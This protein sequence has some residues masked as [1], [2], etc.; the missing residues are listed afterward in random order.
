MSVYFV[1][2]KGWRYDFTLNG[3]RYTATWFK[4]KREAV[5]AESAKRADLIKPQVEEILTDMPFL[6][7]VN[8][9]LDHV[10]AY[11]SERHYADY[12]Y[13]AR[14]W[15]ER[16]GELPCSHI[17]QE[18]IEEFLMDRASVSAFTAN[19][20]LRYLRAT[21]NLGRKRK[22]IPSNPTD[23]INF[24]PVENRIRYIPSPEEIDQVIGAA[25]RDT[26]DYLWTI[27]DTM[28]R[29][30]EVNRLTWNDIDLS[31]KH[32]ILYTRKKKG[33]HLTP[34]KIPLTGR[35]HAI[36]VRRFSNRDPAKP[37]IFWHVYSRAKNPDNRI[38]PYKDRKKL[39]RK[40]CALAGVSYFRFHALR[41]AGASMLE[42]SNVPIGT[43][44][45][46]LGHENRLTTELY[47]HSIGQAERTA[48]AILEDSKGKSHTSL[49][50]ANNNGEGA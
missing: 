22:W 49:T 35:L 41:H 28:A 1:K 11:N 14:R 15:M 46:I 16:W 33:G 24:L 6:E 12:R 30:S 43:I 7:L 4:T 18:A 32:V 37:W 44:Q 9:R 50:Q 42:N 20:E 3:Q 10:Q 26:Q 2:N 8:R 27:R 48:I 39:M 17:R 45:R 25:D 31:Q 19:K 21:F 13:M 5:R 23:G 29:M 40:L 36:L 38:G 34:R 47:L